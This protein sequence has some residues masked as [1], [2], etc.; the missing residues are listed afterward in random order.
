MTAER[1]PSV[2]IHLD[3][4]EREGGLRL[5]YLLGTLKRH[6]LLIAGLTTLTASV[7]VFKA[8]TEEPVYQSN[9]DLLTPSATPESQIISNLTSEGL[10]NGP[11]SAS[12]SVDETTLKI[13]RSPRVIEPI[14]EELRKLHPNISYGEIVANLD[15]VPDRSG[16][17]LTVYYRNTDSEKVTNVLDV[18]LNAYLRYSLA[19]RQNDISRGINFVDEQLPVARERVKELEA[20]LEELRQSNNLID[21][22]LQGEQLTAQAAKFSSEQFDLRVQIEQSQALYQDLQEELAKGEER[23]ATSALQESQRYQRLLDRLADID[24]QIAEE[25]SVYLE[26]SP[27]IEVMKDHRINLQPLIEQEGIR[28][29]D[30][31]ASNIRELT[32]LDRA[33]S[34]TIIILNQ[35]IKD[36]STVARQYNGIQRELDIA[37]TNLNQFLTKREALRIDAAQRKTPWELLTPAGTPGASSADAKRNLVLGTVLGLLLGSGAAI[38]WDR[39]RGKINTIKELRDISQ[40]PLLA[41]IPHNQ[42]LENGQSLALAMNQ[43]GQLGFNVDLAFDSYHSESTPFLE[44]FKRLSTNL[45]LSNPDTPVQSLAISS[46][47]P[48]AG[49]STISFHLAQINASMGKRT[50]LV[51][52][53]MRRPTIHRLC[54]IPN[55]E[56]LSSYVTGE[57]E[58]ENILVKLP[59]SENL[60][61]TPVGPVPPDPAQVLT[62]ER[63]EK[64]IQQ[65]H[66][67]FDM[68]IFDTPP[69][70][71]FA[72]AFITA[73]KTQGLLLVVR[74]GQLKFSQ[75]DATMDELSISK[76]PVVGMVANGDMQ[77]NKDSYSYYEYYQSTP[78]GHQQEEQ[79]YID[80]TSNGSTSWHENLLG[81]FSKYLS[82]K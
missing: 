76:T 22:L 73:G 40:L 1:L 74:L 72:D 14:V 47:I 4:Q 19:D 52:T 49:K 54:N 16:N 68:V 65:V 35:Q 7:A 59:I 81:L 45:R 12:T 34:D 48:N 69:L 71:G 78:T 18:V 27:E 8:I 41:T 50:L 33:L 15:I 2:G 29:Q 60:Y 38:A 82:K 37:T 28:V 26:D 70:L 56:G 58:L 21:P 43:L 3:A 32:D 24:S 36:L 30:E 10:G 63:M 44:A 53:D 75:L 80:S 11:N 77:E 55:K 66:E 9:F 79:V 23:A 67:R 31:V 42:L 57:L 46:A 25:L 64:F 61:V 51:D 17:V 20:Q 62:S 5:D 13:L 6:L 39:I